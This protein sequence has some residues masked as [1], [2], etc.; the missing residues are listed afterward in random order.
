M[1]VSRAVVLSL[2]LALG[3]A[4]RSEAQVVSPYLFINRC[5]GTC[6][7][8]GS[9]FNDARAMKSTLPCSGGGSCAGGSCSCP[10]STLGM[11]MIEEFQ[12]GN[13]NTG[14][15]ADPEWNA[16]MECIRK[17]YSPYNIIVTDE[18]P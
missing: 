17:I 11:Y 9:T 1:G 16:I 15:L 13:G 7:V 10:G 14:T 2:A 3:A 8:Y 6:L 12:D 4:Q 18:V 5:K